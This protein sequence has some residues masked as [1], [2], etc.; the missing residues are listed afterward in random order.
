VR[1]DTDNRDPHVSGSGRKERGRCGTRA[2]ARGD[3]LSGRDLG[4]AHAGA[5]RRSEWAAARQAEAVLA[6]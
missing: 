2:R 3:G 5:R 1:R 4:S 6:G